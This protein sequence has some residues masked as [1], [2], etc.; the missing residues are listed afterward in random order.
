MQ[1]SSAEP[2]RSAGA[3]QPTSSDASSSCA[4]SR[5]ALPLSSKPSWKPRRLAG[6]VQALHVMLLLKHS[7]YHPALGTERVILDLLVFQDKGQMGVPPGEGKNLLR[8][9]LPSCQL[10]QGQ[11]A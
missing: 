9:Q 11:H 4:W 8:C 5:S 3:R 1:S 2:R 6:G 10:A 7:L